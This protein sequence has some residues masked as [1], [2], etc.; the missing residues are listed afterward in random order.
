M[1]DAGRG[2]AAVS[3]VR[4][5]RSRAEFQRSGGP[6]RDEADKLPGERVLRDVPLLRPEL[7][8]QPVVNIR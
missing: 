2:D 7:R 5:N 8:R 4:K 3:G 1:V 6:L